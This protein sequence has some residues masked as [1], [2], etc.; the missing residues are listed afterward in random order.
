MLMVRLCNNLECGKRT[1][2]SNDLEEE[3]TLTNSIAGRKQVSVP[4]YGSF[5]KQIPQ[6][7]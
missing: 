4:T 7:A 2:D 6:T 5:N 1:C 3:A